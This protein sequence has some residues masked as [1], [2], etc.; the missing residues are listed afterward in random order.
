[1]YQS[2][3][4]RVAE[5][6]LA[7]RIATDYYRDADLLTNYLAASFDAPRELARAVAEEMLEDRRGPNFYHDSRS[8]TGFLTARFELVPEGE[9]G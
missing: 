5:N 4:Q 9:N 3:Y 7:D 8:L 2:E 6:I 1:M